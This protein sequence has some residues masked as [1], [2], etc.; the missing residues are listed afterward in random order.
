MGWLS[1]LLKGKKVAGVI[2]GV[3][4][5][6]GLRK[7][8]EYKLKTGYKRGTSIGYADTIRA[9]GAEITG[10]LKKTSEGLEKLTKTL[11]KQKDIIDK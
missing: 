4:P 10:K 11:K 8:A 5:T 2:K 7:T 1:I 3:K 6:S 9:A